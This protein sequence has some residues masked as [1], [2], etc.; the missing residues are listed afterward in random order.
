MLADRPT[1]RLLAASAADV[2]RARRPAAARLS[3]GLVPLGVLAV[4]VL[5]CGSRSFAALVHPELWAE[6]GRDWFAGAY[7]RGWFAPLLDPHTGYLQTFPRLVAD[8]GLVVPLGRLPLLFVLIALAVQVLPAAL[9]A[10]RR[11][12]HLVP[13]RSVR[14]LL[15]AAYLGVPNSREVNLNLTNAQWHLGL[16]AL[17]VVLATPA[18]GAWR[19]LDV[20]VV[21]LS[22]LTGPFCLALLPVAVVVL[23]A[24]REAWSIV[25][26]SCVAACSAVQVYE[27]AGSPRGHYGPLGA[28][29]PRLVEILGGEVV[30]GTFL[31]QST[32]TSVLAGGHALV[33]CS[34]LAGA[35]AL[36][37]LA[38]VALGPLELRLLNVFAG[39]V[40][41]AS[42]LTPV[43]SIARPQ[44]LA[45]VYDGQMRYWLYP[46]LAL[47]A[48]TVW[49]VARRRPRAMLAAGV[50]LA[51]AVAVLGVPQDWHY[52][53]LG[54]VDWQAQVSSFARVPAGTRFTFQIDPHPWT[55]VLVKR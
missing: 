40:L 11:F 32:V 10:S 39:L 3:D 24:R 49:L 45:L 16:L 44:W 37:A 38:A 8:L 31:G 51:G 50:V 2:D 55:M 19:V 22:G 26:A 13:R 42:L 17:L 18:G 53:P 33:V 28:T 15:A 4:G 9:V 7:N 52:R 6:D 21:V 5:V 35:G 29:L 14:L 23:L 54:R 20:A 43:V 36:L 27:L 47:L 30:G 1:S 34:V 41:A 48:D 25:L 46:T 12:A